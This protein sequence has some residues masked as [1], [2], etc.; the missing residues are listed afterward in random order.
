MVYVRK[1]NKP[2]KPKARFARAATAKPTTRR[3]RNNITALAKQVSSI[4]RQVRSRTI[5]GRFS[6]Q[7]NVDIQQYFRTVTLTAPQVYDAIFGLADT[8]D[9]RNR[10]RS[11]KFSLDIDVWQKDATRFNTY[12]MFIVSLKAAPANTVLQEC[13]ED[14]MTGTRLTGMDSGVHYEVLSGKAMMNLKMFNLHYVKRFTLGVKDTIDGQAIATKNVG[15]T[16]KRLYIK[17]PWKCKIQTGEQPVNFAGANGVAV[18]SIP[19]TSKLWVVL[20]NDVDST[21]EPTQL[22]MQTIWTM[23]TN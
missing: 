14:L 15:D 6:K 23:S 2:K 8:F 4:Q 17:V 12:T 7:T 19:D 16:H 18:E 21:Q 1:T 20:F 9:Q 10:W 5:I 11:L 22:D 3:N 13:G